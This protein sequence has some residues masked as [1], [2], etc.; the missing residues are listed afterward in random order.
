MKRSNFKRAEVLCS[1]INKLETRAKIASAADCSMIIHISGGGH[2]GHQV[3][4][5]KDH[6]TFLKRVIIDLYSK[7]IADLEKELETL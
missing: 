3:G 6:E 2:S 5:P 1:E 7:K 4:I